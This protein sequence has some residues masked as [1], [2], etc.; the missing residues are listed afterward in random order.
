MPFLKRHKAPDRPPA[1]FVVGMNRSGTTLLRLM[2][3]SH[4]E[5]TI[6]PETHFVPDL[7][8]AFDDAEE[9]E[10]GR[11]VEIL[12]SDRHWVDFNLDASELEARLAGMGELDAGD[13]LRAF[14]A[15][16]AEGQ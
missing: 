6:P 12:T 4:P 14:Y 13:A 7:I 16:Y 9:L 1:P 2:L 8:E 15:L 3:D 5:M 11:V 10:A